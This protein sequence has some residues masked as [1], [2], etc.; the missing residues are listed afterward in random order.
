MGDFFLV[1][2]GF[3][4][5]SKTETMSLTSF[6]KSGKFGICLKKRN[7]FFASVTMKLQVL[8]KKH[9][10]PRR[11][12][13]LFQKRPS[14]HTKKIMVF[15]KAFF[16]SSFSSFFFPRVLWQ[17]CVSKKKKFQ[18]GSSCF[19]IR[20]LFY[21]FRVSKK[22]DFYQ[23]KFL[24][25]DFLVFSVS[26]FLFYTQKSIVFFRSIDRCVSFFWTVSF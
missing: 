23:V 13:W 16:L 20:M 17:R 14:C 21:D 26:I 24:L 15:E 1:V 22:W 18:K 2:F 5:L 10:F 25:M 6:K 3:G 7:V 4:Q 19:S 8:K 9:Q 12:S 11:K